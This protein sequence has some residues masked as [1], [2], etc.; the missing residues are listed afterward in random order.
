MIATMGRIIISSSLALSVLGLVGTLAMFLSQIVFADLRT[1]SAD[2][3][4]H[5]RESQ[6][7]VAELH[8]TDA[9][10]MQQITAIEKKLD[11]IDKKLDRLLTK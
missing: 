8:G 4:T 11:A 2:F 1:A 3:R 10:Q 5:E 6:R 7:I 9:L